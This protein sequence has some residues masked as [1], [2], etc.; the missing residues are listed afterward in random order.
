MGIK[1][2]LLIMLDNTNGK[3]ICSWSKD[4]LYFI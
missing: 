1:L 3:D 2:G 4:E